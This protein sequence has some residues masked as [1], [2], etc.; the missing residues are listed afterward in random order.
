[1]SCSSTPDSSVYVPEKEP[2][3]ASA[4]GAASTATGAPN[5]FL[6]VDSRISLALY[7]VN[8]S[9]S[10]LVTKRP[11]GSG[12]GGVTTG[13]GA[14][15][16]GEPP[17][18]PQATNREAI[19]TDNRMLLFVTT[20]PQFCLSPT[21]RNRGTGNAVYVAASIIRRLPYDTAPLCLGHVA[22][23]AARRIN[24]EP[25]RFLLFS[26]QSLAARADNCLTTNLLFDYFFENDR[27]RAHKIEA[28]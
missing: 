24:A 11:V 6:A 23:R 12:G 26:G 19:N 1:M 9:P 4:A 28:T 8:P 10:L 16:D 22:K 18:P 21:I 5:A 2:P 13:G 17:P 25:H 7:S 27:R 15:T 3:P 14:E 20:Y